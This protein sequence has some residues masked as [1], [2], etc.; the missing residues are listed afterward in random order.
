MKRII[1]LFL[2]LISM[3]QAGIT[4]ELAVNRDELVQGEQVQVNLTVTAEGVGLG[5]FTPEIT[6]MENFQMIGQ[7]QSTNLSIINGKQS[8]SKSLIY[9]LFPQAAGEFKL[10]PASITLSGETYQSNTLSIRVLKS[11]QTQS[12]STSSSPSS[13]SSSNS[14]STK[15]NE[16]IYLQ[17]EPEKRES[18]VY[19]PIKIKYKLFT[20]LPVENYT[21]GTL[22]KATNFWV[23][24]INPG[25]KI[26]QY[27]QMVNNK[28]YLVAE[29]REVMIYPTASGQQSISPF[30]IACNVRVR[31]R[32]PFFD[33][34]F[35]SSFFGTTQKVDLNSGV[36]SI[37]VNPLPE[38]GKPAFFSD[39]NVGSNFQIQALTDKQEVST[40]EAITF[41]LQITGE[42]NMKMLKDP[43][44]KFPE[45]FNTYQ[46][47]TSTTGGE[48]Q[49]TG[50]KVLEYAVIPTRKGV[51]E[52][53]PIQF[54][55][56]DWKTHKYKTIATL[57]MTIRVTQGKTVASGV[58]YANFSPNEVN[59][60]KEDIRYIKTGQS[61]TDSKQN[62]PW[63]FWLYVVTGLGLVPLSYIHSRHQHK[64]LSD[65]SYARSFSAA[66]E[67]KRRLN[68]A[69]SLQAVHPVDEYYAELYTSIT[70]F[71]AD[72]T[73]I[74]STDL[75]MNIISQTLARRNV[76][77]EFIALIISFLDHC[78]MIRFSPEKP[79]HDAKRR[80][81]ESARQILMRLL[82]LI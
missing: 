65:R 66:R 59:L 43:E 44:I 45:S 35:S 48:G 23:E 30:V 28:K 55:F 56:F 52:I 21:I 73:C 74:E 17:T 10:G 31:S 78:Q 25:Q 32:D 33:D 70:K 29:I 50:K 6:G 71:I 34:F 68:R 51:F 18:Y 81:F 82:K 46:S 5:D 47:N 3:V 42:G 80:D 27:Y 39:G 1:I 13:P 26:K 16:D 14:V 36:L 7:S 19:E 38:N 4:V 9:L 12:S 2:G 11:N 8:L 60:L 63:W 62:I 53:P 61:I 37:N 64:L 54:A 24:E 72:K 57:L 15:Q 79:D 41:R 22:P 20:R 40:N 58:N 75:D 76:V 77:P 69:Q 67:A 49:T